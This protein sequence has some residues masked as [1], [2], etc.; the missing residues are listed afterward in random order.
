MQLFITRVE[1][2]N[3]DESDYESLHEAMRA[4]GFSQKIKSGE[5]EVY[6]LPT[7]EYSLSSNAGRSS[8]LSAAKRA[9]AKTGCDYEVLVSE[10]TY[11]TWY[12]L[13]KTS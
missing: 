10:T 12:G 7:A 9:A 6:H 4:E 11:C 2:H 3:A 1:L 8:V 13:Q 5:G